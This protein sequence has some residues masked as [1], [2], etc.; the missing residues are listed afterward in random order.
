MPSPPQR[1]HRAAVRALPR[2]PPLLQA[3]AAWW[4]RHAWRMACLQTAGV[5]FMH[6]DM[7]L[8]VRRF[9]AAPFDAAWTLRAGLVTAFRDPCCL[10]LR[11]AALERDGQGRGRRALCE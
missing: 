10:P 3:A 8:N 1:R 6:F 7:L 5:L 9:H 2:S 11:S 4:G